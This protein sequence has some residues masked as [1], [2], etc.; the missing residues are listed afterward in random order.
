MLAFQDTANELL[1][2]VV[3][4]VVVRRLAVSHRFK[5]LASS[6]RA[7]KSTTHSARRSLVAAISSQVIPPTSAN[8]DTP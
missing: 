4:D 2:V 7:V 3:D 1:G 6:A 5:P 8:T